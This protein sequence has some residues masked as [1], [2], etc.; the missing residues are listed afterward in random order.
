MADHH[1]NVFYDFLNNAESAAWKYAALSVYIC[2]KSGGVVL[3][4]M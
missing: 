2:K 1:S 3:R 4:L